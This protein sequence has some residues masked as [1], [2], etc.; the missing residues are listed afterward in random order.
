M[1]HARATL[2]SLQQESRYPR[3]P[4]DWR[5]RL[6]ERAF[7]GSEAGAVISCERERFCRIQSYY[8]VLHTYSGASS[9]L[10]NLPILELVNIF[11]TVGL[12]R[13]RARRPSGP[14]SASI[15]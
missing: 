8:V 7:G 6:G 1:E 5:I 10:Q 12:L 2:A 9:S 3:P 14:T 15:I 13:P 4:G 11:L